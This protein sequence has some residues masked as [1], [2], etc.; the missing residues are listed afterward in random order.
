M[1]FEFEKTYIDGLILIKPKTFLDRRGFF[2]ETFKKTDFENIGIN[3]NFVQDNFSYSIKNVIRGLH[4]QREPKEQAKLVSCIYGEIFDVA[5]DL[6][7][8]SSTYLK[9]YGVSL[10]HDNGWMLYIPRGFAHGFAVKSE[11][12][13]VYYKCDEEYSPEYD[14]GVRYDDPNIAIDWGIKEPIIS[15]KDLKLP[16]L[17]IK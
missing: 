13:C 9:W 4:Y 3:V 10:R 16:F 14:S 15:E 11:F 7:K 17:Y 5:V 12:A 6:R 2:R 1:P 8:N